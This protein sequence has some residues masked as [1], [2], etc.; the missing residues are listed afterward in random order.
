MS[1]K[2]LM[3]L[4][5][6]MLQNCSMA[7]TK[8]KVIYVYDAL[9]GWCYGFSP[10]MERFAHEYK[11]KVDIEVVSGGLRYD[12]GAVPLSDIAPYI[13]SAYKTVENASGVKFGDAF[14][15][16]SL[17]RGD[18]RMNSL[19][20]AIALCL[21]RD[22]KPQSV[23]PFAAALHRMIYFDGHGPEDISRYAYYASSLGV[24]TSGFTDSM[25]DSRYEQQARA[26]F[27]RAADLGVSGFPAVILRH[28][29]KE[30][31]LTNGYVS[32]DELK[33]AVDSYLK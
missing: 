19:P 1:A 24:D 18:I 11:D 6:V 30:I 27:K 15:N 26:D 32:F 33:S 5:V 4:L 8:P 16:G 22:R 21:V 14:V 12:D 20:P 7:Q 13:R 2:Y 3:L 23:L 28:N 10:V 9:C 29:G 31:R 17:E 25:N